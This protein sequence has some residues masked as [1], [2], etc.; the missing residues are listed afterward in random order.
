MRLID[1]DGLVPKLKKFHDMIN[2]RLVGGK[3]VR[4]LILNIIKYCEIE[5]SQIDPESLRPKARWLKISVPFN[6]GNECSNCGW[7]YSESKGFPDFK[8]CPHC[9]AKMDLG[10]DVK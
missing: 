3:A 1:A 2:P 9:G 7:G 10:G 6:T 4:E 5:Q 8:F